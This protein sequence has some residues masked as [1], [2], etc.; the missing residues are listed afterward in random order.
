MEKATYF[1]KSAIA[2]FSASSASA[3][4]ICVSLGGIEQLH[5][6]FHKEPRCLVDAAPQQ[7]RH[8]ITRLVLERQ[9]LLPPLQQRGAMLLDLLVGRLRFR[10]EAEALVCAVGL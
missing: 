1:E 5:A 8:W 3:R 4:S 6:T 2:S 7:L 9:L 10:I